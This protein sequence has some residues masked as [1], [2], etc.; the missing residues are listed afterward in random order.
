MEDGP[1]IR[2]AGEA[3]LRAFAGLNPATGLADGEAR[4]EFEEFLRNQVPSCV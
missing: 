3:T 4:S 1:R 2:Q